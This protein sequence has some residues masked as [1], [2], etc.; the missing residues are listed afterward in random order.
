MDIYSGSASV[1]LFQRPDGRTFLSV[2]VWTAGAFLPAVEQALLDAPRP[3]F[4][5][6]EESDVEGFTSWTSAGFVEHRREALF[7]LTS[8]P[9]EGEPTLQ[10]ESFGTVDGERLKR[11][12]AQIRAEVDADF[13]WHRMP[14]EL[15]TMP[16]PSHPSP[17]AVAVHDGQDVGLVRVTGRERMRR[18]SLV[19]VLERERR[20]GIGTKLISHALDDLWRHGVGFAV[21]EVD[22]GNAAG[23][24][25]VA[26]FNGVRTGGLIEMVIR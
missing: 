24:A 18:I 3:V 22:E 13:G 23:L 10:I 19:A 5:L 1:D 9:S 8:R 12:Y 26:R 11:L 21:A 2:D 25:L 16:P 7:E 4:T 15:I 17:Y 14:A 6:L 20:R